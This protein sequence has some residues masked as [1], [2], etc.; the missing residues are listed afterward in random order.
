MD[1]EEER[2]SVQGQER[3][4]LVYGHNWEHGLTERSILGEV[5]HVK[6]HRTKKEKKI[7]RSMRGLP[8]KAM[9][10]RMSWQWQEQCWTK[11]L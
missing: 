7:S 9:R 1:Y 10:R 2:V 5:G 11:G 8:P 4:I 3:E 6:A